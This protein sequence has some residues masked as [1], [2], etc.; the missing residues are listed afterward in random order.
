MATSGATAVDLAI[1]SSVWH[2]WNVLTL[3]GEVDIYTAPRLKGAVVECLEQRGNR[4]LVDL[5]GVDFIDSTGLGVLIGGVK[6]IN[7][8]NSEMALVCTKGSILRLL[9]ITGLDKVFPIYRD[10][11]DVPGR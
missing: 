2:S 9:A 6:R 4:L 11:V 1:E 10:V 5:R 3:R 7:E 8:G